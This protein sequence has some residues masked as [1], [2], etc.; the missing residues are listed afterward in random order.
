M[1]VRY[2]NFGMTQHD[3]PQ[4]DNNPESGHAWTI[5]YRYAMSKEFSLALEWMSVRT[6]RCAHAYYGL[7]PTVTEDQAQVSLLL[8]F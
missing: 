5:G 8:R 2:D 6:H 7:D 1:S 4:A 3:A